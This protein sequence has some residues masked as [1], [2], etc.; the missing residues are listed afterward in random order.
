MIVKPNSYVGVATIKRY[1][2][3]LTVRLAIKE[4]S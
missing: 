2:K 3:D 4:L 1:I